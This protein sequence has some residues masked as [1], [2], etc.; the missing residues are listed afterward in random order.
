MTLRKSSSS[1]RITG[2][3]LHRRQST[4]KKGC[5]SHCLCK[6]MLIAAILI[7]IP[8]LG[9]SGIFNVRAFGAT[10]NGLTDDAPAIQ[11]AE[12]AAENA[13]GGVVY[14]PAGEYLMKSTVLIGSNIEIYGDGDSSVLLR[15]DTFSYVPAYGADC[16]TPKPP[17][18][19]EQAAFWN[20]HYNC[21]D[22]S[23]HLHDLEVDGSAMKGVP[24]AVLIAFSGL[25][26]T[27]VDHITVKNAPQDAMFFRNGGQNLVVRDNKILLHDLHWG[28]G[29]GI[30]V[31]MHVN[32][33]IWGPVT[34][35]NNEIV[36]GGPNFCAGAL[37]QS[38]VRN[39]DCA[40]LQP[41]TCGGGASNSTAIGAYWIDGAT[42]PVVTI[43]NNRIWVGNNHFGVMCNG[44]ENS[45]IS[46]NVILPAKAR[47]VSG[48]GTYTGISS[49]SNSAGE[50]QNLTIENNTIEGTG[51][52][53]DG[54]A[55]LVSGQGSGVGL[56]I[57]GNLIAHKNTSNGSAVVEV[58]GLRNVSISGNRLCFVPSNDI[59]MG[60]T[61]RPVM[62]GKQ[63]NNTIVHTGNQP[64]TLPKEC[65]S[66]PH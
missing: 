63:A 11:Q 31:E 35:T 20:R 57:Q 39:S 1:S 65:S 21:E 38:C 2:W 37:N 45:T 60:N 66:L 3:A 17:V 50:V 46:G 8:A 52:S 34:I 64:G 54:R 12:V 62:N 49:Y 10:G 18:M 51:E 9:Q 16:S 7:R 44:C 32:G 6:M 13:G 28:N 56:T 58:Q 19:K 29:A 24:N 48:V 33:Q 5:R 26:N 14:I 15:A 40:G 42:P 47:Q 27:T 4:R 41:A 55:I 53:L 43:T 36:T 30:N 61:G 22:Q 25:A 59:R 23:I